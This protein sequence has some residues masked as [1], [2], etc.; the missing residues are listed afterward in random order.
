M[1]ILSQIESAVAEVPENVGKALTFLGQQ[2]EA[3]AARMDK[4]DGGGTDTSG[5]A[6]SGA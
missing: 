4:L 2:L 6:P 5:G 1:D 3:L